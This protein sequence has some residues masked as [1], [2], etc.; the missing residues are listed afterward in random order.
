MKA[1]RS[2]SFEIDFAVLNKCRVKIIFVPIQQET[3]I[4]QKPSRWLEILMH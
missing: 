2:F 3:D 4:A 1:L